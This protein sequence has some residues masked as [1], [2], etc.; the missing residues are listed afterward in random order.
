MRLITAALPHRPCFDAFPGYSK[1][2][3]LR[4]DGGPL[5]GADIFSGDAGG[6]QRE[7][8]L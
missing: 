5:N 3:I 7:H 8:F 1:K 4:K 2:G 6:V